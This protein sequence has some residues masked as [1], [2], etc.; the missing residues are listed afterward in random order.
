MLINLLIPGSGLILLGREWLGA[1]LA[2]VFGICGHIALAGWL[3]APAAVPR[4]WIAL[5]V[6]LASLSWIAAQVLHRRAIAAGGP[7][8]IATAE[9]Q[10]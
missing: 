5:A 8:T 4:G 10:A 1:S 2:F 3:I 7:R 9:S 6:V